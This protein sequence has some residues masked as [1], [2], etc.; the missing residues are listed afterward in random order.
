[1]GFP[2]RPEFIC[3]SR[4]NQQLPNHEC[5]ARTGEAFGAAKPETDISWTRNFLLARLRGIIPTRGS[6]VTTARTLV[7][8]PVLE[9][10]PG[11]LAVSC[12]VAVA[13]KRGSTPLESLLN[14]PLPGRAAQLTNRSLCLN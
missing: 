7:L 3:N 4:P 12:L 8:M 14:S 6:A 11:A 1:M 10:G 13:W 9:R 5:C 2:S